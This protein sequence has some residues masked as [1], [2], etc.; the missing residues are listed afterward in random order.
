[1]AQLIKVGQCVSRYQNDVL[2]YAGRF[3]R[4][5]SRRAA[6]WDDRQEGTGRNFEHWLF[7]MQLDW[8]TRTADRRS[9][10]P[11]D[12]QRALWVQKLLHQINDLSFIAYKP[13]LLTRSGA[14]QL[15]SLLITNDV[16]WCILS[17]PG[18]TGS[19]FQEISGRRWREII[20]GGERTLISPLISL[21]RTQKVIDAFLKQEGLE[22]RTASAVLSTESFIEFVPDDRG[23]SLV[24]RRSLRNWLDE[25]ARHSLILKKGQ[26]LAAEALLAHF[27]TVDESRFPL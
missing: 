4:L 15:D 20:S 27:E 19:V 16:V 12:M 11:D 26:V 3:L 24:D 22:M 25:I 10:C 9:A 5:K 7:R 21:K 1:M 2:R 6:E 23:V 18:E 13:V 17:L 8:A 14:V